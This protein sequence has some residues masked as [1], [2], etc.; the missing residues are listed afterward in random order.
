MVSSNT[1]EPLPAAALPAN[2]PSPSSVVSV[3]QDPFHSPTSNHNR[4]AS[5]VHAEQCTNKLPAIERHQL[6]ILPDPPSIHSTQRANAASAVLSSLSN[7]RG[8]GIDSSARSR[9]DA[10]LIQSKH[11]QQQQQ[12]QQQQSR[13]GTNDTA[14]PTSTTSSITSS[15]PP[16]NPRA[17]CRKGNESTG[18]IPSLSNRNSTESIDHKSRD[19]SASY[20]YDRTASLVDNDEDDADHHQ[21]VTAAVV[22]DGKTSLDDNI[23]ISTRN[24][25]R[26]TL[27]PYPSPPRTPN[28][29]RVNAHGLV[30][31]LK[32]CAECGVDDD[33]LCDSED[34][35]AGSA[36]STSI[37]RRR[38]RRRR[39]F[40]RRFTKHR[41]PPASPGDRTITSRVS[42][43]E[44]LVV[45]ELPQM[46][47]EEKL[48]RFY[49]A[50]EL[51]TIRNVAREEKEMTAQFNDDINFFCGDLYHVFCV[52]DP[53]AS[54]GGAC[55]DGDSMLE[56]G[57][58]D[59]YD[60]FL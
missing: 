29:S 56:C 12:Q 2:I 52:D 31:I 25:N 47:S 23:E 60:R 58:D 37:R 18:V 49:T 16:R 50:D 36:G 1:E 41:T 5:K 40:Q 20:K 32:G 34:D 17:L 57:S 30:S 35:V 38:R 42:F 19:I 33:Y 4:I 14:R 3:L 51:Q 6:A 39:F 54:Y 9:I 15:T 7:D 53:C 22:V 48:R 8:D 21:E 10:I 43:S 13:Q 26:N 11:K 27:S 45:R 55:G 28:G 24:R 59:R 46:S 44:E